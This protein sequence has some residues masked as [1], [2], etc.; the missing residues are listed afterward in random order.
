LMRV[1][2]PN[3][4]QTTLRSTCNVCPICMFPDSLFIS[5]RF[6]PF[7]F[8][9]FRFS[10]FSYLI[11]LNLTVSYSILTLLPCLYNESVIAFFEMKSISN[12]N[13]TT[14]TRRL[15][16]MRPSSVLAGL[17]NMISWRPLQEAI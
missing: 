9:S 8:V 7:C 11:L 1:L 4:D 17:W 13:P 10:K 12:L 14:K 16:Q 5:F 2:V 3:D 6:V 15:Q